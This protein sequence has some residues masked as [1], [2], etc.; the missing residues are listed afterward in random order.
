M[1]GNIDNDSLY[2]QSGR[3]K[4][5]HKYPLF[6]SKHISSGNEAQWET[7][8]YGAIIVHGGATGPGFIVGQTITGGTSGKK[9]II[10]AIDGNSLTYYNYQTNNLFTNGEAISNNVTPTP[11]T[12]VITTSN[13]GS[14]HYHDYNTASVRLQVG[15]LAGQKTIR[16][17][18][19]YPPYFSGFEPTIEQTFKMT[20][21]DGVHQKVFVGDDLNGV[22]LW[23]KGRVAYFFIRSNTSGSPVETELVP[24][25]AEP[26]YTE[27]WEDGQGVIFNENAQIQEIVFKW[28]GFGMA[29]LSYVQNDKKVLCAFI[30]HAGKS[31]KVFMRTPSLPA[32]FEIE[33]ITNQ[34]SNTELHV[35][36]VN[37]SSEGGSIFPGLELSVPPI[38]AARQRTIASTSGVVPI[39]LVRLKNG[40]PT[41]KPNRKTWRFLDYQVSATSNNTWFELL[42]IHGL[43]NVTINGVVTAANDIPWVSFSD[44]SAM[45]YFQ[46]GVGAEMTALVAEMI[47]T[48]IPTFIISGVGQ[49]G[50]SAT[51]PSE[52]V[53]AHAYISQNY[54]SDNSQLFAVFAKVESGSAGVWWHMSGIE[55][56]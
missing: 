52:F 20:L 47:H 6:E 42:H 54:E 25:I 13:T 39:G 48:I 23:L 16:Q 35:V 19:F 41:G 38:A 9:G 12:A 18:L 32:R 4:S 22:G 37:Y 34:T 49:N 40:W 26:N 46:G 50:Q 5:S 43:K 1:S 7:R 17:M 3:I 2:T 8:C 24:Q 28:L 14:T 36:C 51:N 53:N 29:T 45:E 55:V 10:T 30:Q 33:N 56:E 11:T 15:L 31:N 27:F 21:K 44:I